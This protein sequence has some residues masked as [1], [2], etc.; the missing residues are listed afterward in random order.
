M[1]GNWWVKQIR[2]ENKIRRKIK[3]KYKREYQKL[4]GPTF[5]LRP[6][7]KTKRKYY[8]SEKELQVL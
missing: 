6:R 2:N 1:L 3:N 4:R 8:T 5:S 7:A